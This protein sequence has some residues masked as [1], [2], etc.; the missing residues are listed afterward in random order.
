MSLKVY[1]RVMPPAIKVKAVKVLH[2]EELQL[3]GE[4]EFPFKEVSDAITQ[5]SSGKCKSGKKKRCQR[6]S[7]IFIIGHY[8][9]QP[10]ITRP[11]SKVEFR[12]GT[13][14][15]M[16]VLVISAQ[17]NETNLDV[18]NMS[19]AIRGITVHTGLQSMFYIGPTPT[20]VMWNTL[21]HV[22][23]ILVSNAKI[24]SVTFTHKSSET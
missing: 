17:Q 22:R 24:G 2:R 21:P 13:C 6:V 9:Q 12:R 4:I 1:T 10:G 23:R 20:T 5:S 14:V 3:P 16:S 18:D 11:V 8:K 19:I 15:N 7:I